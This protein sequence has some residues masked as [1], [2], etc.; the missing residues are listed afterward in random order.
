[1][2]LKTQASAPISNLTSYVPYPLNN[3]TL[4]E[5]I[6]SMFSYDVMEPTT[7][8]NL[9]F[10]FGATKAVVK[11]F[12]FKN[13]TTN[14]NLELEFQFDSGI[15]EAPST[16]SLAPEQ[17]VSVDLLLN[18]ANMQSNVTSQ[19]VDFKVRVKNTKPISGPLTLKATA[20]PLAAT[21]LDN[22]ITLYE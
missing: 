17:T 6:F 13:L 12:R 3:Q 5:D 2:P 9:Q 19:P 10:T 4:V 1:M 16:L 21:M 15:F 11:T 8:V 22:T 18:I 7:P 20:E 14:T